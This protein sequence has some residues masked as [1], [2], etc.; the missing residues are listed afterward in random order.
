MAKERELQKGTTP[1][2]ILAVLAD[3]PRH[4]YGVA[5]EIERRSGDRLSPGEGALY[6]ALRALEMDGLIAGDWETQ[7]GGPARKVYTLTEK[8]RA[9]LA[10]QRHTWDE[11]VAAVGGVL[12][13][14]PHEQPA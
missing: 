1:T 14:G 8:G 4:G 11:F 10:R 5:R 12:R 2:L 7:T 13:G 9:E 6:P 3:G